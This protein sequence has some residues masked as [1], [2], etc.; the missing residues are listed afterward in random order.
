MAKFFKFGDVLVNLDNVT[1]IMKIK[2]P[3]N[4]RKADDND[5]EEYEWGL[6]INY[7][8]GY[9]DRIFPSLGSF[10]KDI[11]RYINVIYNSNS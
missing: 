3:K 2:R 1:S 4:K 5:I 9:P 6:Y 7:I 11:D 10:E 8:S